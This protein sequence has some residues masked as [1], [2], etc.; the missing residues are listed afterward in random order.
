MMTDE[1][2]TLDSEI[3]SQ[4][5]EIKVIKLMTKGRQAKKKLK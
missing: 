4:N 1:I 5:Y 3:K 2:K